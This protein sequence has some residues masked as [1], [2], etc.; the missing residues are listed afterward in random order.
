MGKV[1]IWKDKLDTRDYFYRPKVSVLPQS[2]DLR[3]HFGRVSNQGSISSCVSHSVVGL[4]SYFYNKNFIASPLYNYYHARNLH[5]ATHIDNGTSIRY[6]LKALHKFGICS[7]NDFEDDVDNVFQ[8]P[9]VDANI[10]YFNFNYARLQNNI[11]I[12]KHA[13]TSG[14]PVVAGIKQYKETSG[15]KMFYRTG[16]LRIPKSTDTFVN[17]HALVIVG[18]SD[19]KEAFLVRNSEG[20]VWGAS[21]LKGHYWIPYDYINDP[22]LTF[23]LWTIIPD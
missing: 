1:K 10:V 5:S 2:V 6:G 23:D 21:H 11:Y 8:K 18:Y 13:I 3:Q 15:S 17:G 22:N 12:V 20:A 19:M 4:F 14:L 16:N 7:E 9:P